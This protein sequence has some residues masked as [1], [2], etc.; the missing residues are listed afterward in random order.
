MTF[1]IA[2]TFC[3][4]NLWLLLNYGTH[5]TFYKNAQVN[6]INA[7]RNKQKRKIEKQIKGQSLI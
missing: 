1:K 5:S 7:N 2:Q 6:K 4:T 3:G